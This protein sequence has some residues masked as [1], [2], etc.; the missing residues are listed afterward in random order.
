MSSIGSNSSASYGPVRLVKHPAGQRRL[1][2]YPQLRK[3]Q[4]LFLSQRSFVLGCCLLP[5]EQEHHTQRPHR[6]THMCNFR[7][8]GDYYTCQDVG[9][10][11]H[12]TSE[13]CDRG[14]ASAEGR[15]CTLTHI[16]Y[17]LDY[18]SFAQ[19]L[20]NGH[21]ASNHTSVGL[22]TGSTKDLGKNQ[23]QADDQRLKRKFRAQT[24]L[25][26]LFPGVPNSQYELCVNYIQ[27]FYVKISKTTPFIEAG[28]KY[29]FDYH[30][31]VIVLHC[32]IGL[33]IRGREEIP[34]V[35]FIRDHPLS[36]GDIA[37]AL[38]KHKIE[39]KPTWHTKAGKIFG[40]C[41]RVM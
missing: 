18:D 28:Q 24:F 9:N 4:A 22:T 39:F 16:V 29:R 41:I 11:H 33:H 2:A 23:E 25:K 19:N 3:A 20:V 12:C 34:I 38:A 26:C 17:T 31:I 1:Q 30:I 13:R 32:R 8:C 10:V 14:V 35:P 6:C 40:Q 15:V 37:K 27:D 5:N 21:T 7:K 36:L